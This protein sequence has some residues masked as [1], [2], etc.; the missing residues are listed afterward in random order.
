MIQR[1]FL[2]PSDC[3][4]W[5][6]WSCA[7]KIQNNVRRMVGK[8]Q[9]NWSY[10][11]KVCWITPRRCWRI[12][13][14]IRIPI[15]WFQS[16]T[17]SLFNGVPRGW[18]SCLWV[19]TF[20]AFSSL[21]L[22][23]AIVWIKITVWTLFTWASAK[24]TLPKAFIVFRKAFLAS[25]S[26]GPP[27]TIFFSPQFWILCLFFT[28]ECSSGSSW[29]TF[30]FSFTF[31]FFLHLAAPAWS[32]LPGTLSV[33]PCPETWSFIINVALFSSYF[34]CGPLS[35]FIF[36]KIFYGE[37]SARAAAVSLH[38]EWRIL[39][40]TFQRT[41]QFHKYCPYCFKCV[42]SDIHSLE[43]KGTR[44]SFSLWASLRS[45]ATIN[46][47]VVKLSLNGNNASWAATCVPLSSCF[48]CF[49]I[50]KFLTSTSS[51]F[52]FFGHISKIPI[53]SSGFAHGERR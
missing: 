36:K 23:L 43:R 12:V 5:S 8:F 13:R 29:S 19:G 40:W 2:E 53:M 18:K 7:T 37:G 14:T 28:E 26:L 22:A 47:K 49:Q 46:I 31:A 45:L 50:Q 17:L 41:E 52:I 33:V 34:V 20:L 9:R 24:S 42:N 21:I 27:S 39:H 44:K 10:P 6:N 48:Q 4:S 25:F 30:A 16:M 35:K 3:R 51:F 38:S 32:G 11:S 15:A 1:I